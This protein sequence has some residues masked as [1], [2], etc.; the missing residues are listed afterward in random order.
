MEV[1]GLLLVAANEHLPYLA[2]M[3]ARHS[4]ARAAARTPVLAAAPQDARGMATLRELELRLKSV[5][6]IE[7]ITKARTPDVYGDGKII[8]VARSP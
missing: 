6:N 5:R 1:P 7:K 8:R 2:V 4:L 3:L